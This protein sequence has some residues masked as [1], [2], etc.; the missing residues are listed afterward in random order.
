MDMRIL[1]I[2][3]ELDLV[4]PLARGLRR[5]GYA[6]DIAVDGEHGW[7]LS[8]G[9]AYDLLILDLNLPGMDGL[10]ICRH[11]RASQPDLP[12]LILTARERLEDKIIGLDQGADDYLIKPFYFEELLARI[13]ALLRR[14]FRARQPILQVMDITLDAASRV[15][16]VEG[17]QLKLTRKEFGILEFLMRHPGE[18]VSQEQLLE[19]VWGETVDPFTDSIRVHINALRRKLGD[20]DELPHY[21]ET[22]VGQGYRLK[23][24]S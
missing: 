16:W 10:E 15:V 4:Y 9:N 22:V 17:L 5:Q 11:L 19:H 6:V 8:E 24:N 7:E 2:E 1:I 13:R 21:I 18:V 3:D 14:D 23:V 20:D 12:I